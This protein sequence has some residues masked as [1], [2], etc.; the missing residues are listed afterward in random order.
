[1]ALPKFKFAWIELAWMHSDIQFQINVFY[2]FSDVQ[3]NFMK[4]FTEAV[5]EENSNNSNQVCIFNK[6][7]LN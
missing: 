2:P 5:N 7:S 3:E 1:M 6:I 4:G